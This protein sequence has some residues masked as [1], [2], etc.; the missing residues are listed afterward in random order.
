MECLE[1]GLSF[2][3]DVPMGTRARTL[4]RRRM[5]HLPSFPVSTTCEVY[6]EV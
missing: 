2:P 4:E 6:R 1:L 3:P 5:W